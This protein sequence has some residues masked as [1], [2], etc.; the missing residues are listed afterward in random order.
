MAEKKENVENEEEGSEKKS[1]NKMLMII[2]IVVLL[3][4]VLIG[5]VA[6]VLLLNDNEEDTTAQTQTTQV[7]AAPAATP[8]RTYTPSA[9]GMEPMRKLNEIGVLY[10]L[11]TFTVNLKSDSGRRY[12]KVTLDLELS[13]QELTAELDNKTAVIRDRIIRILTSKTLEEVTS[14]KGKDKLTQQIKDTLNAMLIDGQVLGVYF[15]EFVIQ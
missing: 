5:V 6:T 10:P 8:T 3:L 11:D 4:V 7:A 9:G 14:R 1:S 2:I 12:L 15:T 13:G